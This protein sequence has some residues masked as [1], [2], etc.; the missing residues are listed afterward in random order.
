MSKVA[1]LYVDTK[2]PYSKITNV[3]CWDESKD[4]RL[5]NGPDPVIAHP[6]CGR[7]GKMA[8]VNLKRWGAKIGDDNGCFDA[9]LKSVR[10]YGGVLEHP[11]QTIAW[12]TFG[13]TKP[14]KEGW[15]KVSETEWVGE[16]WQSD[17]GHKAT[18]KTWLYFVGNK[19]P[20]DFIMTKTKGTYQVGG[21]VHKNNNKLP[22]L[23]QKETHLT[24]INFA[25]YLV[26]IA[27]ES[28]QNG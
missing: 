4:A 5:Y 16:V 8:P 14:N 27:T 17:Y 3:D 23:P 19:K 1:A 12:K 28:K 13:L 22:R 18:K 15:L 6:P 24:P 10:K 20:L 21:G 11:A 9:A 7:W 25:K 26:K 2:G